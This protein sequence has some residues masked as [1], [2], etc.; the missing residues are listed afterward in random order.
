MRMRAVA[1]PAQETDD[2]VVADVRL[3]AVRAAPVELLQQDDQ[4]IRDRGAHA[5]ERHGRTG[6]V[7]VVALHRGVPSRPGG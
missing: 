6:I 3:G 4:A 1:A 2:E 7:G 5:G